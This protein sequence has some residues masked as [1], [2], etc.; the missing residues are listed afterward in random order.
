[1]AV[2]GASL[3]LPRVAATVGFLIT[4]RVLSLIGK[5]LVFVPPERSLD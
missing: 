1:M 3:P 4:E 2:I 5:E